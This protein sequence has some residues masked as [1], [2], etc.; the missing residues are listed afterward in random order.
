[1]IYYPLWKKLGRKGTAMYDHWITGK[2]NE[3]IEEVLKQ[4]CE[5]ENLEPTNKNIVFSILLEGN[6]IEDC[7]HTYYRHFVDFERIVRYDAYYFLFSYAES[8]GDESI[9]DVG[10]SFDLNS[11]QIV[12][13]ATET[14]IVTTWKPVLNF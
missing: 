14:K 1:M 5:S 12:E 11:V 8:T 9:F 2:L 10:F 4:L 3:N 7:N 6:V 13:P